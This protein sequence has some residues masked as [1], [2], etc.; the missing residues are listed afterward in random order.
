MR[1]LSAPSQATSVRD[2]AAALEKI[3]AAK[4]EVEAAGGKQSAEGQKMLH[5]QSWSAALVRAH[6]SLLP[7]KKLP[8]SPSRP[9]LRGARRAY[10]LTLSLLASA[11]LN[12]FIRRVRRG[13]RSWTT[14][15]C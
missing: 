10:I 9:T 7:F 1:A 3:E 11:A 8:R 14:P 12:H 4:A 2:P 13:K 5:R 6:P 15:A